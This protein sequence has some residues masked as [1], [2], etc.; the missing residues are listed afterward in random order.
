VQGYPFGGPFVSTGATVLSVDS[1]PIADITDATTSLR[2]VY[3]LA[4]Q[5]NQ[6]NSGGPLLSRD[7]AVVGVVFAK[8]ARVTGVGYA[9]TMNELAPVAAAAPA[10]ADTVS[11]GACLN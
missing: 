2:E 4:A 3:T 7:G 10:L 1:V 6:G 9:M 8:A 11:P 5:V